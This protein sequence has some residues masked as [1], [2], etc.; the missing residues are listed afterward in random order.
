LIGLSGDY[1]D[2]RW[3]TLAPDP[4]WVPVRRRLA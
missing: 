2:Q 4:A 3:L 1:A